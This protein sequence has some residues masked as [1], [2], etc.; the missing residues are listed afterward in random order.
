[1]PGGSARES[2]PGIGWREMGL[3]PA[4]YGGMGV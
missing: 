4:P 2:N 3:E 1:M